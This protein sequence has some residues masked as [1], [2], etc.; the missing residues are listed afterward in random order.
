M[1]INKIKLDNQRT[2]C[3]YNGCPKT[4]KYRNSMDKHLKDVHQWNSH[5]VKCYTD[6]KSNVVSMTVEERDIVDKIEKFFASISEDNKDIDYDLLRN[7]IIDNLSKIKIDYDFV[8]F[9][10]SGSLIGC[11]IGF[12]AYKYK[13]QLYNKLKFLLDNDD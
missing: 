9:V 1:I 12:I 4:Y 13:H 11:V 5:N 7:N 3:T 8:L 10:G 2:S 6:N